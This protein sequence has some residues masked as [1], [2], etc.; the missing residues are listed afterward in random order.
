QITGGNTGGAFSIDASSGQLQVANTSALD[1]AVTPSFSLSLTVSDG[2][3]TSAAA[4]VIV[5][6]IPDCAPLAVSPNTLGSVAIGEAITPTLMM[7]EG[8][9]G[10][11]VWSST[12]D[13]PAGVTVEGGSFGGTPEDAGEFEVEVTVVGALGC[14]GSTW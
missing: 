7:V 12:G 10:A 4:T 3:F 14:T 9:T 2:V 8:E 13:V 11:G 1:P 5:D 6:V